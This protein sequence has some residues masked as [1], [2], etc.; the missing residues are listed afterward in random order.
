MCRKR[1]FSRRKTTKKFHLKIRGSPAMTRRELLTFQRAGYILSNLDSRWKSPS[2]P[3]LGPAIIATR[4]PH[5]P[6]VTAALPLS[7]PRFSFSSYP[8]YSLFP[9]LFPDRPLGICNPP[10][11]ISSATPARSL[12]LSILHAVISVLCFLLPRERSRGFYL[13]PLRSIRRTG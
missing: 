3:R 10:S 13:C 1:D 11:T 4:R 8:S 12:Y 9:D 7:L 2:C 5:L 6:G